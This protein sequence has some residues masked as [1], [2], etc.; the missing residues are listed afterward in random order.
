GAE[1]VFD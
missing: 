1:S